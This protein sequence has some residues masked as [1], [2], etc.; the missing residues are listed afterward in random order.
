MFRFANE[1]VLFL[2]WFL[3]INSTDYTLI[4]WVVSVVRGLPPPQTHATGWDAIQ[5]KC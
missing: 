4:G 3:I 2:W 1:P 5:Y